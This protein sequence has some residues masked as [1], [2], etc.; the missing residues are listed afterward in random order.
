MQG[1]GA[2][3]ATTPEDKTSS[4][5]EEDKPG[6]ASGSTVRVER[7][8]E[9]DDSEGVSEA[10]T[11]AKIARRRANVDVDVDVSSCQWRGRPYVCV[12]SWV[13][14][15]DTSGLGNLELLSFS[16]RMRQG[17]A[18]EGSSFRRLD[19]GRFR[20]P[21]VHSIAPHPAS[22]PTPSA[23]SPSP[24]HCVS[25]LRRGGA[26]ALEAILDRGAARLVRRGRGAVALE[27]RRVGE[28]RVARGAAVRA[29]RGRA[30]DGRL[31]GHGGGRR[32]VRPVRGV[33]RALGGAG[34]LC[35]G[36]LVSQF[37]GAGAGVRGIRTLSMSAS[38]SSPQ[39]EPPLRFEFV[40]EG[41]GAVRTVSIM[42]TRI[43]EGNGP[44]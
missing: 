11:G 27:A 34:A 8:S 35:A 32:G 9:K 18:T 44:S 16:P 14:G 29:A 17:E 30:R 10:A 13:G 39:P 15:W 23:A 31:R 6:I 43:R 1:Q 38:V 37:V 33:A 22:P 4:S 5:E 12:S 36:G 41:E 19:V 25:R 40:R 28:A 21:P 20:R 7:R 3:K 24:A 42:Y 2:G 26:G